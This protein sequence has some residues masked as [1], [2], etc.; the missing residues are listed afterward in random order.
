[1]KTDEDNLWQQQKFLTEKQEK[2]DH[3]QTDLERVKKTL[4]NDL[5]DIQRRLFDA[6]QSNDVA[7]SMKN[8]TIELICARKKHQLLHQALS[9]LNL[10]TI[11]AEK[12]LVVHQ[13]NENDDDVENRQRTNRS[14]D[15]KKAEFND[16]KLSMEKKVR[17]DE[18]NRKENE[19][20][21]FSSLSFSTSI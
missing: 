5:K 7:K 20:I 11:N 19:N 9:Q 16:L 6:K 12:L 4:E 13:Q 18:E 1:M 15:Q 2:L 14:L 21:V 17:F 8:L 10:K 3:E